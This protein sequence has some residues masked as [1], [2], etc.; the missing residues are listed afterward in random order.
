MNKKT[1]TESGG[2]RKALLN[3]TPGG[4]PLSP[5]ALADARRGLF[6]VAL[7]AH[8]HVPRHWFPPS[9]AG[10]RVL[11]LAGG[12]GLEAQVL[13]ATGALVTV[14][15]PSEERL[16]CDRDFA[17]REG[18]DISAVQGDFTG[19]SVFPQESFDLLFC[20]ASVPHTPELRKVFRE[21]GRILK[22][23][24]VMML[25][26]SLL[27]QSE[28]ERRRHPQANQY[29]HTL[30]ELIGGQIEAGLVIFGF[31]EDTNEEAICDYLPR[32]FVTRALKI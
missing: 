26:V 28:E 7:T 27:D 24:G 22:H 1:A 19:L 10:R 31:Y 12:Q 11:C 14:F 3:R 4:G 18:L 25:G 21:C 20:P 30:E 5:E 15:S 2:S 8:K 13:A 32:Y 6:D 9:L 29:S 17:A 23:G 16:A